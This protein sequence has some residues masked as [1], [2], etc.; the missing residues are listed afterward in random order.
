MEDFLLQFQRFIDRVKDLE[1][2][3]YRIRSLVFPTNEGRLSVPKYTTD[4]ASPADGDIWYNQTTDK[5]RGRANG[6]SV[7]LH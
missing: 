3:F 2:A 1:T 6:V 7:D 4:P 5:F